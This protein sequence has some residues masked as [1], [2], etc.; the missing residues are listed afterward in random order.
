MVL[1]LIASEVNPMMEYRG[2]AVT[3]QATCPKVVYVHC[4][5]HRLNLCVVS[6]CSVQMAQLSVNQNVQCSQSLVE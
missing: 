1:T 5:A 4:A 2:A 3:V 6:A